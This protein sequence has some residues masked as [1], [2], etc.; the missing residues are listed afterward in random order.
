MTY[1]CV[2]VDNLK[3]NYQQIN[4]NFNTN[5]PGVVVEPNNPVEGAGVVLVDPNRPPA[6]IFDIRDKFRYRY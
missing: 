5:L 3:C 6:A 1:M 2:L 4:I